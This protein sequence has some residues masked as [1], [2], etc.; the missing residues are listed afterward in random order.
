[1]RIAIVS[2]MTMEPL[3]GKLS[4]HDVV[5]T[6]VGSLLQA[7]VDP[8]SPA[9]DSSTDVVV[10]C[11]D[12]ASILP[13]FGSA[14]LVDELAGLVEAFAV[15]HPS[16]FVAVSTLLAGSR[17]PSSFADVALPGGRFAARVN[18][19]R[20]LSELALGLPNVG[21]L[22]LAGL[23]QTATE[24]LTNDA[25][26]YLGRIRLSTAGFDLVAL[27][28]ERMLAGLLSRSRKLLVLDLD[29]TLWGGVVG[30]D[31]IEGLK[32]GEDGVG[33]CFRDF[34][35][36]LRALQ[37][38]GV[39]LAVVSK[40][41]HALAEETIENH[42]M[43]VL[44]RPDFVAV[45]AD[46]TNKADR[47]VALT[48][49][50]DLGLDSVV[51]IDDN[52]A[53]RDL[54]RRTLPDVAV[55][56]FPTRNEHLSSWLT[57]EVVPTHFPRVRVLEEDSAKTANYRARSERKTAAAAAAADLD[58]F[59]EAL[60]IELTYYVDDLSLAQRISQLS[61]K[62]NQ[63][64]LTTDRRSPAEVTQLMEAAD[65]RVVACRYSDRFGDEGIIGAAFLDVGSA[66]MSNLLLS[67]RVLG[68]RVEFALIAE[69]ER[70]AHESG[71][72]ELTASF[73]PSDR[74]GVA[75]S[76]LPAAGYRQTVASEGWT[77]TKGIR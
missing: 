45:S 60:Q 35:V 37:A 44:R 4:G 63:F 34:Q 41:D 74:N 49:D 13:P 14:E 53:E 68:R 17:V 20:R 18:W 7:L 69:V 50:L 22:D 76:F 55:P 3:A 48:A 9:A 1:M 29:N 43:M 58:G 23:S 61:Q 42:P 25:Y 52:P 54:V 16:K 32:L 65:H 64:N 39:L 47:I 62:T 31:G 30:E 24:P 12:G 33:K 51:F 56:E 5:T 19:D 75:A 59:I 72:G 40:N 66:R 67:C 73:L 8:T 70:L 21:V 46:W 36:H 38:C 2:N 10:I 28:V 71:L 57:D 11:P 6:G 77:G 15:R 26:W 27:E